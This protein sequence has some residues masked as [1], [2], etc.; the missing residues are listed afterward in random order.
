MSAWPHPIKAVVFDCDGTLIDTVPMYNWAC[1]AII[2]REYPDSYQMQVNGLNDIE[3]ARRVIDDFHVAITADE[4]IKRRHQLIENILP[5]APL[6]PGVAAI[7]HRIDAMKIPMAIGTSANRRLHKIKTVNHK[8][9]MAAFSAVICGD[10]VTAA[11]PSPEIFQKAAANLGDFKPENVLVF[12]DAVLGIKAANRAG[13]ASVFLILPH[14]DWKSELV[15][16]DAVP[17]VVV[18]SFTDFDFASFNWQG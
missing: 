5:N 9:F 15:K 6:V 18:S 11:K 16:N 4:F 12:E 13:M 3:F 17:S 1:S 7:V 2:G 14:V 10:E 8:Q